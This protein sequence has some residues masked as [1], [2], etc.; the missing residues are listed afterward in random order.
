MDRTPQ[1]QA[2]LRL[3]AL[4]GQA[5]HG[6][7]EQASEHQADEQQDRRVEQVHQALRSQERR[8]LGQPVGHL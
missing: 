1:N 7:A 3:Q 6:T 4:L 2:L 5:A 8:Q